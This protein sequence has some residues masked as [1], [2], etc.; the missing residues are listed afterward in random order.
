M[1]SKTLLALYF[2]IALAVAASVLVEEDAL[3]VE[4][5]IDVKGMS[6]EQLERKQFMFDVV[7]QLID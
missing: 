5:D 7:N 4:E 6:D 2:L 1:A 3:N